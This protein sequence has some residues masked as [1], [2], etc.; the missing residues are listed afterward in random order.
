MANIFPFDIFLDVV[1]I[2][3]GGVE[4]LNYPN[5]I[6]LNNKAPNITII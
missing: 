1:T 6:F 4:I 3:A 2:E 5:S